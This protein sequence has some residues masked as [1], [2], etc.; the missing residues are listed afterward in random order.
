MLHLPTSLKNSCGNNEG[1]FPSFSNVT[2]HAWQDFHVSLGVST[3]YR[4]GP[5]EQGQRK[6]TLKQ[7]NS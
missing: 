3:A 1:K 5:E 7:W 2:D 6:P 4:E